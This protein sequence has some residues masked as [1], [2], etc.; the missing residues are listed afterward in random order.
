M[1]I[2]TLNSAVSQGIQYI[3]K[4]WIYL[5]S[6]YQN[7]IWYTFIYVKFNYQLTN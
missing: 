4:T 6:T 7:N 5:L 2:L 1:H 3:T